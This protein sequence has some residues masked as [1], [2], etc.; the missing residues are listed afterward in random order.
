MEDTPDY[1]Y[2]RSRFTTRLPVKRLYTASHCWLS[3]LEPGLWRVG[4]TKF[5]TRML[6]EIVEHDFE[7]KNQGQDQDQGPDQAQVQVGQV[8]GW[9]EGFK[10]ASDLYCVVEGSF[11]GG[12][13]LLD[14]DVSLVDK[15]PYGQGWLYAVSGE[16]DPQAM[17]IES[18][19][20]L[21]D[22][23]ID[24]LLGEEDSPPGVEQSD[25]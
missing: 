24:K 22:T 11:A 4:M 23:T 15:D 2:K 16:P 6:G 19:V 20:K 1:R 3:E 18:Y 12:N 21:L 14:S 25:E 13:P 17:D 10:A 8:I 7:V 9:I 5:A